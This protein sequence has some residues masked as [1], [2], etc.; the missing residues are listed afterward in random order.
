MKNILIATDFSENAA[1]AAAYGYR[2]A[3]KLQ[4]NVLLCNAFMVPAELPE[5]GMV[6]WPM[7]E[8]DDLLEDGRQ[9]LHELKTKIEHEN[10]TDDYKPLVHCVN[11]AG[12]VVSVIDELVRK[13]R[14]AVTVIG[15]HG[16]TGIGNYILGNHARQLINNSTV[17]LLLVPA[18]AK[19]SPVKKIAF[20]TDFKQPEKDIDAIYELI[21]LIKPLNA[22]LLI[23]HVHHE[24]ENT[25]ETKKKIDRFLTEL[26]NK[27]DYPNI[28]YRMVQSHKTENGLQWLYE[29]GNIDVFAM[30]HRRHNFLE[31]IIPGSYTQKIASEINIPLLV[32]PGK[33]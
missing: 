14:V 21:A 16:Q 28:Y 32:I 27:A 12:P 17:P 29:H 30:L 22:E 31:S 19:M 13:N 2:L 8:Y 4:A 9:A 5:A 33:N 20:A 3:A 24:K 23:A 10:N 1:H 18:V 11:E 15:T 25:A 7:Y 6:T 26:S